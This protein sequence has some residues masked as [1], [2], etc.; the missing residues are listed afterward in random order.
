MSDEI[1]QDLSDGAILPP[2]NQALAMEETLPLEVHALTGAELESHEFL[3]DW[4]SILTGALEQLE[5]T[6]MIRAPDVRRFV[7]SYDLHQL[8]AQAT[9][10][11]NKKCIGSHL[12][13]VGGYNIVYLLPFEDKTDIVARLRIPGGGSMGNGVGMTAETLSGRFLS[14]VVT[15][16]FLNS[17]TISIPVPQLHYW[18]GDESHP[19]GAAYMLMQRVSGVLLGRG[20]TAAAVTR[21]V[22]QIANFEV[23]L[24]D[25]PLNAIGSLINVNGTVGPLVRPCTVGLVPNDRGPYKS[26]KQ[27]LLACV[28]HELDEVRA[29]EEWTAQR[30]E[31]SAFNSGVDALSAEYAERWFQLLHG[32]IQSL[33]EELPMY[34]DVFRLVH[35]DFKDGNF[36]VVS[37]E[38]PTIVAVLDWE[39]ARVLP[40]WDVRAGCTI[41]WLLEPAKLDVDVDREHL[42]QLYVDITTQGGRVLGQ[43]PLCWQELMPLLESSPS[44]TMDRRRLDTRFLRWLAGAQKTGMGSCSFELEAFEPL[45]ALVLGDF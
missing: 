32:A 44:V 14:E 45:K 40:A 5:M 41:E 39:G 31:F 29:T 1:R 4:D 18:D 43:S 36:L 9:K 30:T 37:A 19:V 26:S 7:A 24:Y 21:L 38:D 28:A 33:P 6:M 25:N 16:G 10:V 8:Q 34:P 42:R 17:K 3:L 12:L 27:F 20:I 13:A 11:M 22:T 23:D 15:L 2:L 35:T